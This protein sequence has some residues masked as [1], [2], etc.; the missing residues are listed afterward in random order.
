MNKVVMLSITV[1]SR[2][3]ELREISFIKNTYQRPLHCLY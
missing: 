2:L 1:E 3:Q